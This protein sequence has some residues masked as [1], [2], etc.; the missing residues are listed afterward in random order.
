MLPSRC[1]IIG[2]GNSI[3]EGL[4]KGLF[5]EI[6]EECAFV[7]NWGYH[8]FPATVNTFVDHEFYQQEKNNIDP[9]GLIIGR[10]DPKIGKVE[11][12]TILL[13]GSGYYFGKKSIEKNAIYSGALS[14]LFTLTLAISLGF[15]EIML[16]GYDFCSINGLT[17]Y[18]QNDGRNLG[19]KKVE[20][21][22]PGKFREVTGVGMEPSDPSLYKTSCY[23][24]DP[25]RLFGVYHPSEFIE[26]HL[27]EHEWIILLE[28]I[29]E[30]NNEIAAW[31]SQYLDYKTIEKI[32]QIP[33]HLKVREDYI[34]YYEFKRVMISLINQMISDL[35]IART[36]EIYYP[37]LCTFYGLKKELQEIKIYNVS[38]QSKIN[39]FPKLS[40]D[41]FFNI[42]K[43]NPNFVN[44]DEARNEI[45][46]I[47]G[48]K[49]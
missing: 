36:A 1:L 3:S 11:D 27:Q 37:L 2:S 18:Y 30:N 44:Q 7:I 33:D 49:K 40:Y 32:K 16:L 21:G 28:R 25:S 4:Q 42:M 12:N 39:T 6:K 19:I 17:H 22:E 48:K 46:K 5:T 23:N 15:R 9:L 45:K 31:V 47:I 38:P 8:D 24:S 43:S 34:D 10:F 20:A 29:K 13:N 26:S 35:G 41:E 14:G